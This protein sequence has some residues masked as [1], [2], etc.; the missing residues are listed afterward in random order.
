[1]KS[2]V[3]IVFLLSAGSLG[4]QVDAG[5]VLHQV[6]VK[7]DFA[8]GV[9]DLGTHVRLM[10][11]SG[12]VAEATANEH[13][14]VEF[15]NIPT[16][17][18]HLNVSGQNFTDTDDVITPSIGTTEFKVNVKRANEVQNAGAA[19]ASAFVSAANLA[20]PTGA[21][22]EFDKSNE[23]MAHQDFSKAMQHLNRA[24]TIYPAYAGAFNNLGV[25]YARL[26]DR[27]H[28]REALQKALSIDSR[29]APAYVNLGRMDIASG[30]FPGAENE[31]TKASAYD[32]SDAMTLVLLTYSEFMER[33][34]DQAIATS[35]K[36]HSLTGS[37]AFVHQVAAHAFEQKRDATDAISEL[38]I[39]LKEEPEGSRA[40]AARKELAAVQAI[41]H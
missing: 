39:F 31:L 33:H 18:Y 35:R 29:F 7:V 5:I 41:P 20:I 26:G 28:E 2:R 24:I 36:A 34:F 22:R 3:W 19:P 14:E 17:T 21:Q 4:A 38:E 9:C 30:D 6:R 37:H 12:P 16:G 27:D 1:M 25:I 13:C 40:D 8:N 11:R 15:A 23:L 32:P 10:S